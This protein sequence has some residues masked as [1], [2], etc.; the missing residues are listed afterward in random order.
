MY[1]LL[2]LVIIFAKYH[3]VSSKGEFINAT[4]IY[5][6]GDQLVFQWDYF[7]IQKETFEKI[8][9]PDLREYNVEQVTDSFIELRN[10]F[11]SQDFERV[12]TNKFSEY[13]SQTA[14]FTDLTNL[15][16]GDEIKSYQRDRSEPY[17]LDPD[18]DTIEEV[19]IVGETSYEFSLDD[20]NQSRSAWIATLNFEAYSNIEEFDDANTLQTGF[21][22]STH[23]NFTLSKTSGIWFEVHSLALQTYNDGTLRRGTGLDLVLLSTVGVEFEPSIDTTEDT[24]SGGTLM[25]LISTLMAYRFLKI[26]LSK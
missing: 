4:E 3:P 25:I 10:R 5:D 8:P 18:H 26:R 19:I 13:Y 21:F 15:V 11:K 7:D 14:F 23:I 2:I 20:V 1:I 16:I 12:G 6:I 9:K 17:N 24:L 22:L